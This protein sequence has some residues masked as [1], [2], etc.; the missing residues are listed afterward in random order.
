MVEIEQDF[1]GLERTTS[2]TTHESSLPASALAS[3]RTLPT[4][5]TPSPASQGG[6]RQWSLCAVHLCLD[7]RRTPA[8][9]KGRV[10]WSREA[11]SMCIVTMWGDGVA[12]FL[13]VCVLDLALWCSAGT[14]AST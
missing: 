4:K 7:E 5:G 9:R 12:L 2:H 11:L 3:L 14:L 6:C 13:W 8:K 1:S 10:P